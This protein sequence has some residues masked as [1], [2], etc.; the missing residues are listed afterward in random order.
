MAMS[1]QVEQHP[2]SEEAL[3][4]KAV[5]YVQEMQK[6]PADNWQFGLWATL[7][8]E[9]LARAALSH[10]SPTLLANRRDWR[11]VHHAL[12]HPAT[13]VKFLPSSTPSNEVL[14]MLNEIIPSFTNELFEACGKAL[15]R[16]NAELH[17]GEDAF[18]G[19]GTSEWLPYFYISCKVLLEFMGKGLKDLFNDPKSAE[20]LIAS[21]QDTAA[22][23]VWGEIDS[24]T[25]LWAAKGK[26]EQQTLESQAASWAIRMAGHRTKCPACGCPALIRGSSHGDVSSEIGEDVVVQKQSM[27]PSSF[28]CVACKLRISGI[29]KLSACGLGDAFTATRA[30]S[31]AEFFELYTS[32]ELE[33]A[34]AE[35]AEPQWEPDFND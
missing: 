18:A 16:R 10:V 6:H 29:S 7:S 14:S 24:H 20:A 2:W 35:S 19:I 1:A 12:G 25:K 26:E 21:L 22:K 8:I 30:F 13:S 15:V 9:L 11:N 32:K 33:E 17:T 4:S 34:R 23:A 28:E 3:F 27:L 31:P 5:L